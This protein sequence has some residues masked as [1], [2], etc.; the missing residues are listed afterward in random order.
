[1]YSSYIIRGNDWDVRTKVLCT[2]SVIR[3]IVIAARRGSTVIPLFSAIPTSQAEDRQVRITTTCQKSHC[4]IEDDR[5]LKCF[6][7]I[8][9]V[10]ASFNL[11]IESRR[12]QFDK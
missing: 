2:H 3:F 1:M 6:V 4:A 8:L 5:P 7:S 11:A 10:R 9:R 12:K